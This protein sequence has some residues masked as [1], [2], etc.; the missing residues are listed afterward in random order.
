VNFACG[1]MKRL[2]QFLTGELRNE[3]PERLA[4]N[5]EPI[6]LAYVKSMDRVNRLI[7]SM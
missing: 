4:R 7:R 2:S 5:Y 6:V 1:A 3:S